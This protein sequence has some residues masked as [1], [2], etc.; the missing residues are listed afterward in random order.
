[1]AA[2]KVG[3]GE[4]EY[5]TLCADL[6]SAQDSFLQQIEVIKEKVE[7]INCV[8]GG[9]YTEDVSPNIDKILSV[10]EQIKV[11]IETIHNSENQSISSFV[12]AIDNIDM[13]S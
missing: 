1:M 5:T 6:K 3:V 13:C 12:Q 4:D 2:T 7:T 8:E 11:S 10:L 9:F